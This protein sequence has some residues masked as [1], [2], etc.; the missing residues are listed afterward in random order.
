MAIFSESKLSTYEN[1]PYQYKLKYIEK[2]EAEIPTT[3]EAFLGDL[4]HKT[5]EKL[6]KDLQY[7]KLTSK[8][9]LLSFF[10][11]LWEKE[12]S[13][14]ILIVKT[15]YQPE[16]YRKMGEK[17]I[18]DYYDKY[19]P[20][21]E[22]TVI[23]IE[24]QDTL[25][26]PDGNY[27]AIRIDKLGFDKD[28]NYYVCDYKT[29]GSFMD[30]QLAD[31]DR[32]LAM[33]SIWVRD[34]FRDAKKIFLKWHLLAF[35]KEII[36]ERTDQQLSALQKQVMAKI[37]EIQQ[38]TQKN[39]FPTRVSKFCDYCLYQKIC[40]SFSHLV[41]LQSKPMHEYKEDDGLK[42][43]EEYISVIRSLKEFEK[44]KE[45]LETALVEFAKQ[46]GIDTVYAN[47]GSV[48]I[49]EVE[50]I[51]LPENKEQLIKLLKEK[52]LYE[53]FYQLNYSRLN[54]FYFQKKL[55]IEIES[56]LKVEKGFS[57]RAKK[58]GLQEEE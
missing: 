49:K 27:W 34:R 31:A 50:K 9:E 51:K 54:S 15:E 57:L 1:C 5:M 17:F 14:D 20:F 8:K 24:T 2:V 25:L 55:P 47:T 35:N 3:I 53:E 58:R 32:Q 38:A 52:G 46:K 37:K 48:S 39:E 22:I 4:V 23:G 33:Y 42:L 26:L 28:N 41:E 29:T 7:Q 56:L 45:E 18:S 36:S 16:N 44:R 10:N 6:Y 13:D 40:P 12:Y 43:A 21:D 11:T 30:Q 19:Y